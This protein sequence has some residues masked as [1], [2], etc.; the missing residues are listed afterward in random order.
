MTKKFPFGHQEAYL[1][2]ELAILKQQFDKIVIIPHDEFEYD[3]SKN[4]V[5]GEDKVVIFEV[6]RQLKKTSIAT[7]WQALKTAKKWYKIDLNKRVKKDE[8]VQHKLQYSIQM[9]HAFAQAEAVRKFLEDEFEDLHQIV[10]YNYW[11]H[12][13]VLLSARLKQLVIDREVAIV[14]RAHSY[15]IY[16]DHW[17]DMF[18]EAN[19][20]FLP[21][22]YFKLNVVD[23]IFTISDH[24]K[25]FIKEEYKVPTEK[26]EVARLGVTDY[27]KANEQSRD[28]SEL[29][30]MTCSWVTNL[31]RIYLM[32][33]II[34]NIDK[35]VRWVHFGSGHDD[36]LQKLYTEI[37]KYNLRDS[38]EVK[39][40][41]PHRDII[42]F[43]RSN[44]VDLFLNLST[45]EG[46]PVA[47]MEAACFGVPLVATNTVGNPEIVNNENGIVVPVDF[48]RENLAKM[49]NE[50]FADDMQVR[51]KRAAS[52]K[53]FEEF[54]HA[55]K[56]Y[57]NFAGK[58]KNWF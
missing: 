22:L 48:N 18:K 20:K 35:K 3:H 12:R 56:N 29:L 6:N 38:C 31:K 46:I 37:D 32:P 11:L 55:E 53:T 26:I 41:V 57:S 10:L 13:G 17:F 5:H 45:V 40:V 27:A 30:I 33:E 51:R 24:G 21:F 8:V 34:A 2:A 23:K 42:D 39:G 58:L 43:Y 36:N 49:I 47:L 16:H 19:P 28:Q 7:K 52:R 15:D 50:L 1:F 25:R 4:R 44:Y 9:K 14:S 54:Y